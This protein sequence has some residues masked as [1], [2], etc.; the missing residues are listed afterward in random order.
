MPPLLLVRLLLLVAALAP[1]AVRARHLRLAAVAEQRVAL[2]AH[3][4]EVDVRLGRD[5]IR[6]LAEHC[7]LRVREHRLGVDEEDLFDRCV[8][9][10]GAQQR[11]HP[12]LDAL[13]IDAALH[14]EVEPQRALGPD[15]VLL[16]EVRDEQQQAAIALDPP[17]VDEPLLDHLDRGEVLDVV[18]E[19]HRLA[20]ERRL[21]DGAQELGHVLVR[22]PPPPPRPSH[23]DRVRRERTETGA[24]ER[25]RLP[26]GGGLRVHREAEAAHA[27]PLA[28]RLHQILALIQLI[29]PKANHQIV[30]L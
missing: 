9:V 15:A 3:S 29:R 22:V 26:L 6:D 2:V 11:V 8:D 17:D 21:V 16:E 20:T 4:R 1:A 28:E 30:G 23:E 18:A 19:Q 10:D 5:H 27:H 24:L 14:D 13:R 12:Q 7:R 25:V